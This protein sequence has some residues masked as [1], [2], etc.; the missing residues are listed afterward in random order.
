MKNKRGTDKI[1]SIYW[2]AILFI[3]AGG[4]IYM[5]ALFYGSPF[6]VREIE[7]TL[8][9]NQIADCVSEGGYVRDQA[10]QLTQ[11][12]FL[13][14]C[15][16]NF[17]VENFSNWQIQGPYYVEFEISDFSSGV[18]SLNFVSQGNVNLKEGCVMKGKNFPQCIE[19]N[20]YSVDNMNN[21]YKIKVLSVVSKVDKNV[22]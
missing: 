19:R 7:A 20:I 10:F 11:D 21:Q 15:N 4:I 18:V 6:D 17:N 1:L 13:E 14:S 9:S 2:F 12:N 3:V 22:Q 5:V 16:L 8:L